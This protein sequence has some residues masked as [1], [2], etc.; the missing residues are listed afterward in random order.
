MFRRGNLYTQQF[1]GIAA[2][3]KVLDRDILIDSELVALD[4]KWPPLVQ[5]SS[6][7]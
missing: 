4:E 2:A 3:G 6:A 5:P 7:F 1:P